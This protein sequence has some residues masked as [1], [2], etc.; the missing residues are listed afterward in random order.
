MPSTEVG[1][2][3]ASTFSAW[4]TKARCAVGHDTEWAAA[5]SATERAASPT[6]ALIW[7]REPAGGP[8]PRRDLRDRLGERSPPAIVLPAAPP[9]LVPP[10]H[11]SVLPVAA[12]VGGDDAVTGCDE[13][14]DLGSPGH[15]RGRPAGVPPARRGAGPV[16][17]PKSGARVPRR[18]W[19]SCVR[20]RCSL[21]SSARRFSV[22]GSSLRREN[23]PSWPN[24]AQLACTYSETVSGLLPL[25]TS[26]RLFSPAKMPSR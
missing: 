20:R 24:S 13:R 5:T 9:S 14:G 26:T 6:A 17:H 23:G 16:R 11:D 8:R 7:V 19:R 18:W 3:S 22:R 4:A 2:G 25:M 1:C 10:H 21:Y 12:H 15:R